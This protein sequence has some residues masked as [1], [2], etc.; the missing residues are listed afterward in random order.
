MKFGDPLGIQSAS[1]SPAHTSG[2]LSSPLHVGGKRRL[3]EDL[4]SPVAKK[5]S[6]GLDFV[7]VI[8]SYQYD[9]SCTV[10]K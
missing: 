6:L 5:Q 9:A 7:F 8:S 4:H 2:H 10:E 1:L 3:S